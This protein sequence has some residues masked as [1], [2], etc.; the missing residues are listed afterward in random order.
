[1]GN[2]RRKTFYTSSAGVPLM[3]SAMKMGKAFGYGLLLVMSSLAFAQDKAAVIAA[4]AACGTAADEFSTELVSGPTALAQPENGKALVYVVEVQDKNYAICVKCEV[5]VKVGLDGSWQGATNGNSFLS[6][7]V[8]P[9]KH[10]LCATWQS[11][12]EGTAKRTSLAGFVAESGKVYF[13]RVHVRL[14]TEYQIYEFSL[15]PVDP[16]EG[17]LLVASAPLAKSKKK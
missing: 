7:S 4:E 5:T 13:F 15:A 17:K 14:P 9:G 6:F 3:P 11:K 8:P 16:D 12:L 2:L 1:M 10:H